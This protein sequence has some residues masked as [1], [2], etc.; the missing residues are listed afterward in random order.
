MLF[1]VMPTSAKRSS[2]A[3]GISAVNCSAIHCAGTGL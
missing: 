3:E 1:G 2:R